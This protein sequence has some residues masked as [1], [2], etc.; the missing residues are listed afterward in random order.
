M[1]LLD[2][3]KYCHIAC[4]KKNLQ[5]ARKWREW[6]LHADLLSTECKW[7]LGILLVCQQW[8][9]PFIAYISSNY[10]SFQVVRQ[11]SNMMLKIFFP[12]LLWLTVERTKSSYT[13][14][15]SLVIIDF[16]LYAEH[17]CSHFGKMQL[18]TTSDKAFL[19]SRPLPALSRHC[20]WQTA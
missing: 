7:Q 6:V 20:S 2:L 1:P 16:Q 5:L 3:N 11:D 9:Y 12:L 18:A 19:I 17:C 14:P 4:D 15:C 10:Y 8:S 13:T